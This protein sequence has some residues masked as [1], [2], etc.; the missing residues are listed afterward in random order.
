VLV[1]RALALRPKNSDPGD[2]MRRFSPWPRQAR[3]AARS[4][5]GLA[6]IAV[7][8]AIILPG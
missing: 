4:L 6:A 2:A 1:K 5:S 8:S 3:R 7:T